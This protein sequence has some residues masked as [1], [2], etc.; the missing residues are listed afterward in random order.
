MRDGCEFEETGNREPREDHEQ[1]SSR[2]KADLKDDFLGS[3]SRMD[4]RSWSKAVPAIQTQQVRPG[5]WHRDGRK[6]Q[7]D[8]QQDV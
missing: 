6:L 8:A 7:K 1:N 5:Q 4:C 3:G 2:G